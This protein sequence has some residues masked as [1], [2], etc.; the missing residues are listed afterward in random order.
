VI[1]SYPR[2]LWLLL[3]VPLVAVLAVM[4]GRRARIR[5]RD[6]G[7]QGAEWQVR[8]FLRDLSLT[9]FLALSILAAA[10]PRSGRRPETG[11]YTGMDIAVAFDVSRSMLAQDTEPSRLDRSVSALR[12]IVQ[13]LPEARFSLVPFKGEAAV[14]VPMTEDRVMVDMWIDRLGPALATIPGTDVQEALAAAGGSFPESDGRN[15]VVL[16]ISDGESLSGRISDAARDLAGRGIPV[17]VLAAGTSD[18]ATIPLSDGSL[19]KDDSGRPVVSRTDTD[20]LERL[21]DET[22]G[23]FAALSSARAVNDLIAAIQDQQAFSETRGIRFVGVYRYR[24]FLIP[25]LFFLFSY[26]LARIVPWRRH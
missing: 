23:F 10:E 21:A 8:L 26:L 24:S 4:H 17:H 13:A 22:G 7:H 20:G 12:Q 14:L 15:R 2:I 9:A 19:V 16:L 3:L 6:M 5:L 18:G 11:E 25:A 1:W